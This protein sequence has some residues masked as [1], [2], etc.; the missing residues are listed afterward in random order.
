VAGGKKFGRNV[1]TPRDAV[2]RER[3][4]LFPPRLC[5]DFVH[6]FAR[7]IREAKIATVMP[8]G[9]FFVI[10]TEQSQDRRV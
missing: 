6:H 5:D 7:Y 3:T 2:Q 8:I 4:R 1:T 10:E 9:K